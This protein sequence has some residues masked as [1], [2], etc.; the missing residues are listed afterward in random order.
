MLVSCSAF[1]DH[2]AVFA[3]AV[4]CT[5]ADYAAVSAGASAILTY[6]IFVVVGFLIDYVL[7]AARIIISVVSIVFVDP[8]TYYAVIAV[9]ISTVGIS[10]YA[11]LKG[12]G[13]IF[14][15]RHAAI[16]TGCKC[17]T[18]CSTTGVAFFSRVCLAAARIY[19]LV[20]CSGC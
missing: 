11:V 15:V 6:G 17:N 20:S 19:F 14:A 5:V 9:L 16:L 10:T 18:A 8:L 4:F 12:V 1:N 13:S 3:L 2:S 7:V